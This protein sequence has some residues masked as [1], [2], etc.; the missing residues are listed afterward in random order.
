MFKLKLGTKISSI[1]SLKKPNTYMYI[2]NKELGEQVIKILEDLGYY[3]ESFTESMNPTGSMDMDGKYIL[4][5]IDRCE[6]CGLWGEHVNTWNDLQRLF[7][8]ENEKNHEVTIVQAS[9]FIEWY[10]SVSKGHIKS[11]ECTKKKPL[12]WVK[13]DFC[14]AIPSASSTLTGTIVFVLN[15]IVQHKD[16]HGASVHAFVLWGDKHDFE[17]SESWFDIDDIDK[18]IQHLTTAEQ[19]DST[20]LLKNHNLRYDDDAE[21]IVPYFKEGDVVKD[22]DG[23][24]GIYK[25]QSFEESQQNLSKGYEKALLYCVLFD[26]GTFKTSDALN[27]LSCDYS[28]LTGVGYNEERSK[29]VQFLVNETKG[30]YTEEFLRLHPNLASVIEGRSIEEV[31][32]EVN[33]CD[34]FYDGEIVSIGDAV[35]IYHCTTNKR[36]KGVKLYCR[37]DK[38]GYFYDLDLGKTYAYVSDVKKATVGEQQ[39]L[40][41]FF[42]DHARAWYFYFLTN[43]KGKGFFSIAKHLVRVDID[44]AFKYVSTGNCSVANEDVGVN[45]PMF[46]PK[47]TF[48]KRESEDS[49]VYFISK[50]DSIVDTDGKQ[51]FVKT[52][53]SYFVRTGG[54]VL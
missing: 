42:K 32:K 25:R 15:E 3:V 52:F 9:E 4:Y 12:L 11:D 8:Y 22:K 18:D 44:S 31:Q 35:G 41:S 54:F 34:D 2:P 17:D 47:G 36:V 7:S 21:D 53:A 30:W 33:G 5:S 23:S 48:V 40:M 13:G 19:T 1:E 14:K 27:T 43:F 50:G 29:F 49:V 46:A 28:N 24:I 38:E 39:R 20:I 16:S 6:F 26:D 10:E 45:I 37:L 51:Q